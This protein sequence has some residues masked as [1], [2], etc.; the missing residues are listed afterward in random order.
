MALT[1]ISV[2]DGVAVEGRLLARNGA[3]TLI[4]D[5]ITRSACATDSD[6]GSGPGPGSGTDDGSGTGPGSG[7]RS[8]RRG[9]RVR[10]L[11]VPRIGR[12][13]IL[14]PGVGRPPA[15]TVCTTRAFTARVRVRDGA[16]IRMV[17]VYLDG[18]LVKRTTHT[19]F[20]IRINVR[21]LRVGTH[22]IK[23]IARD[24]RGNRSVTRTSFARCALALPAPRFTG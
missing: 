4:N 9:P 23:V 17:R 12:P 5:T 2:N 13:Q 24:R 19:R 22:R 16:G 15:R 20:S 6:S 14:T 21:G 8:D 1:S 18:R 10:F 3:V 7:P 11:R